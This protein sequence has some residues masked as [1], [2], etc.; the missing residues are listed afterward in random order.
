MLSND[1]EV[2]RRDLDDTGQ[3]GLLEPAVIQVDSAVRRALKA[4]Q[5][6]HVKQHALLQAATAEAAVAA[7]STRTANRAR[8]DLEKRVRKLEQGVLVSVE[9]V[10]AEFLAVRKEMAAAAEELKSLCTTP[11]PASLQCMLPLQDT[12]FDSWLSLLRQ[13]GEHA[14]IQW[15][16]AGCFDVPSVVEKVFHLEGELQAVSRRWRRLEQDVHQHGAS[17]AAHLAAA[18]SQVEA[19]H[20]GFV[21]YAAQDRASAIRFRAEL[22][23]AEQAL[24]L[25]RAGEAAAAEQAARAEAKLNAMLAVAADAHQSHAELVA[26]LDLARSAAMQLCAEVVGDHN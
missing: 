16:E 22:A 8:A 15:E 13:G 20:R 2:V 14:G 3:L 25:S 6:V 11:P 18:Q 21:A 24:E 1:A 5:R 10:T 19:C 7:G 17:L 26:V 4:A 23:A 9:F 12:T